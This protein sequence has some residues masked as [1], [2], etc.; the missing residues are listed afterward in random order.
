ME[1]REPGRKPRVPGTACPGFG[2]YPTEKARRK[3]EADRLPTQGC[4]T[5]ALQE[6]A[7]TY[8]LL[9]SVLDTP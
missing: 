4:M 2:Q 8:R 5:T 9:D 3:M 7:V 6:T 1:V